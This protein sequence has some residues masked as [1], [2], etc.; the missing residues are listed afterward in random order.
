MIMTIIIYR[1]IIIKFYKVNVCAEKL[2]FQFYS[3]RLKT[4]LPTYTTTTN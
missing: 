1:V 2:N 4:Y 3:T